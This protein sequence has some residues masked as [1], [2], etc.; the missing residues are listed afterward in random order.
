SCATRSQVT[1]GIAVCVSFVVCD[2]S[3]R[4]THTFAQGER[5]HLFYEFAVIADSDG[6]LFAGAE[7]CDS[8]GMVVHGKST[9]QSDP[10]LSFASA[11]GSRVS[12]HQCFDLHVSPG[13]YYVNLGLAGGW[14]Q[15]FVNYTKGDMSYEAMAPHV[16]EHCRLQQACSITVEYAA[17]GK[18]LHHGV[19]DLPGKFSA[20]E[21]GALIEPPPLVQRKK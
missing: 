8:N 14:P 1:D 15:A 5:L 6:L 16:Q 13:I 9:L 17:G 12:V 10:P 19:A 21:R 7:I 2:N 20:W 3:G 18:L 4:P 11:R